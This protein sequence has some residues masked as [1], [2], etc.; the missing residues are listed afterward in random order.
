MLGNSLNYLGFTP[1]QKIFDLKNYNLQN[2]TNISLFFYQERGSFLDNQGNLIPYKD[3]FNNNLPSN[4]FIDNI[5]LSFGFFIDELT[6]G[7]DLVT[8]YPAEGY[9]LSYDVEPQSA[10]VELNWLHWNE[11]NERILTKEEISKDSRY[12]IEW[13]Q[14]QLYDDAI[15][16]IKIQREQKSGEFAGI[17]SEDRLDLIEAGLIENLGC[18]HIKNNN[19]QR[20]YEY[21][22]CFSC[23]VVLDG[24]ASTQE[25]VRAFVYYSDSTTVFESN[26]LTFEGENESNPKVTT[27]KQG[28][29]LTVEDETNGEY[30]L[31]TETQILKHEDKKTRILT[32]QYYTADGEEVDL[33]NDTNYVIEWTGPDP[34]KASMLVNCQPGSKRTEYIYNIASQYNPS[35]L[36][37]T[38]SCKIT[39]NDG[40]LSYNNYIAEQTFNFGYANVANTDQQLLISFQN[41]IVQ[42]NNVYCSKNALQL[43]G[44]EPESFILKNFDIIGK[45]NDDTAIEIDW[46]LVSYPVSTTGEKTIIELDEL[47]ANTELPNKTTDLQLVCY[48]NQKDVV[49]LIPPESGFNYDTYLILCATAAGSKVEFPLPV[50][51]DQY[52]YNYITGATY[53]LYRQLGLPIYNKEPYCIYDHN[54]SELE[55]EFNWIYTGDDWYEIE[56]N[57]LIP[58]QVYLE[59]HGPV[60]V[61][62][63]KNETIVWSQPITISESAFS[64][65]TL[66][67]WDGKSVQINDNSVTSPMIMAGKKEEDEDYNLQF[68]GVMMGDLQAD[69][70]GAIPLTG[71]YGFR[72]G[73]P[74]FGFKEDGTAF[75]GEAGLGRILFEGNKGWIASGDLQEKSINNSVYYKA[76]SF[77]DLTATGIPIQVYKVSTDIS[78]STI[79]IEEDSEEEEELEE[80]EQQTGINNIALTSENLI[81]KFGDNFFITADGDVSIR[82]DLT[83]T[84]LIAIKAGRIASF[85]FDSN[86]LYSSNWNTGLNHYV[87]VI[88]GATGIFLGADI[89]KEGGVDLIEDSPF[90]VTADGTFKAIQGEIGGWNVSENGLN[91]T[92]SGSANHDYHYNL[93]SKS[94]GTNVMASFGDNCFILNDGTGVFENAYLAGDINIA[95]CVKGIY[96]IVQVK[97]K[98]TIAKNNYVKT[99]SGSINTGDDYVAVAIAGIVSGHK[100]AKIVRFTV[101]KDGTWTVMVSKEPYKGAKISPTLTLRILLLKSDDVANVNY[102]NTY[103]D[104]N[105]DDVSEPD[106]EGNIVFDGETGGS[107]GIITIPAFGGNNAQSSGIIDTAGNTAGAETY[108]D[109]DGQMPAFVTGNASANLTGVAYLN[110]SETFTQDSASG[111]NTIYA[112][113][114][115]ASTVHLTYN[116]LEVATQNYIGNIF[117]E[118]N[119]SGASKAWVKKNFHALTAAASNDFHR[120]NMNLYYTKTETNNT[121]ATLASPTFT[122]APARNSDIAAGVQNNQLATCKWVYNYYCETDGAT[123]ISIKKKI[124]KIIEEANLDI[125][126]FSIPTS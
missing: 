88:I 40:G 20:L 38:I 48:A 41:G 59:T 25:Q 111:A 27:K 115:A 71:L 89:T 7:A 72:K 109:D 76:T 103:D 10:I 28:I 91:T 85:Q 30:Y 35:A 53:V 43:N 126:K 60:G 36:E 102:N 29:Y 74:S 121:F 12:H 105:G 87:S 97:K 100:K 21:D 69:T 11:T 67:A 117:D 46:Y 107:S 95:G 79:P 33:L 15:Q 55:G 116:G 114:T 54:G 73:N 99:L 5:N 37:N 118:T 77:I 17:E 9:V 104:Y 47:E 106:T 26:I 14:Y 123:V 52:E 18:T 64:S 50:S 66:S 110:K 23:E 42:N 80:I 113:G 90:W 16:T 4:I 82:G 6:V 49:Y 84:R 44:L 108:D 125:T 93:K 24:D 124:N 119:G 83:A 81:A 22:D 32:V 61:Q 65:T 51:A 19:W 39:Y 57:C 63:K 112:F 58:S 56:N 1:Q 122:G 101:T 120:L 96:R 92:I 8:I 78:N 13:Y 86:W 68:T 31:Y 62:C 75:I 2:I 70:N 45:E 34:E 3:S 98:Y 94:D